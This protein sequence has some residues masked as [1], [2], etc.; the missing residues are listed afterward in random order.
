MDILLRSIRRLEDQLVCKIACLNWSAE[1]LTDF[2]ARYPS[3]DFIVLEA[4]C[5]EVDPK[6][7]AI[8]SKADFIDLVLSS[9]SANST[10][11][12]TDADHI[13]LKKLH[14]WFDQM[15]GFDLALRHR[16][17]WRGNLQLEFLAGVVGVRNNHKGRKAIT[18]WKKLIA[19]RPLDQWMDQETLPALLHFCDTNQIKVWLMGQDVLSADSGMMDAYLWA[20]KTWELE[21]EDRLRDNQEILASL[22]SKSNDLV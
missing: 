17:Q 21:L 19:D 12:Y 7:M 18:E 8:S 9:I 1:L 10:V 22:I 11:L 14:P 20:R 16:P 5:D 3:Y 2:K 15:S 13:V 4:G 6:T